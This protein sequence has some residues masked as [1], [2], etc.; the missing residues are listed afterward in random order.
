MEFKVLLVMDNAGGYP[1]FLPT[2]PLS[3][4]LWLK[5]C[6]RNSLQHLVDAMDSDENSKLKEYRRNFT[7]VTNLS[8]IYVALKDMKHQILIACWKG[9]RS[10]YV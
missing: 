1:F 5:V 7:I 10:K 4:G 9:M 8:V 2:P 6:S 3:S